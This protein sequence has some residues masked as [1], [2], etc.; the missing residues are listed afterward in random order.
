V[1]LGDQSERGWGVKYATE[2]H[3]TNDSKLF[4]TRTKWEE[5]GYRPDEYGYWLK[6]PWQPYAGPQSVLQRP[7]STVLSEDGCQSL[8]LEQI[9]GVALATYNAKMFELWD[10]SSSGWV[11]GKG[12]GAVWAELSFP[13]VLR[14]EYLMALDDFTA[15]IQNRTLGKVCF[16]DISTAIHKRTMMAA[17]IPDL[18]AVNASPVLTCSPDVDVEI[19]QAVVGSFVFDYVAKFKIGYLHLNYF[20]IEECPLVRPDRLNAVTRSLSGMALRL[21]CPTELFAPLWAD[22]AEWL[23]AKPWRGLWAVTPHERVRLK[24]I[25]DAC[26]AYTYGLTYEDYQWLL[27]ETDHP[28]SF[29]AIKKNTK[30]LDQKR[31]WRIDKHLDP[32]LRHTVLSQVAFHDLLQ[33]GIE[34]FLSQNDGEGWLIPEELRLAD[35][36]LGRDDRANESQTVASRLGP[37]F[38]NWQLE[39]DAAISWKE[40]AAHAELIRRIVP[41]QDPTDDASSTVLLAAEEPAVY[42][43]GGLF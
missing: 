11:S 19:L 16:K 5:Q 29:L 33:R 22:R 15:K 1:L 14:P 38:L 42:E 26:M 24:S 41:P 13:K 32:E 25:L 9:E 39:E 23:K 4:P 18:P 8:G 17:L 43:Q 12:R 20:I 30:S 21:G 10:H 27:L 37:R 35:F 28:A 40:C 6:G 36:G 3:M 34:E 2:F 7:P 31:F